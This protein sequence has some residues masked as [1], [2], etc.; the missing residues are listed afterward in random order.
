[1]KIIRDNKEIELT[2][3]ELYEAHKE[4]IV[5]YMQGELESSFDIPKADSIKVAEKAYD[6]YSDGDGLSQYESMQKAAD[7]YNAA[8]KKYSVI[9]E[10]L[11]YDFTEPDPQIFSN[12]IAATDFVMDFICNVIYV[13]LS[14][15][16]LTWRKTDRKP[17]GG[18]TYEIRE[19]GE[20]I[21]KIYVEM[22]EESC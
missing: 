13:G 8:N 22:E 20:T 16:T 10:V 12:R 3:Q 5:L 21:I 4:F 17:D 2:Y 9:V 15:H 14:N 19:K 18:F 6:I 7:E 1:M 11:K